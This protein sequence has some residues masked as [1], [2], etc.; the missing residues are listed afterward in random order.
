M[1]REHP[2][3]NFTDHI[4]F[5][6]LFNFSWHRCECC[7]LDFRF[8]SGWRYITGPYY[9]GKGVVKYICRECK[10]TRN[11]VINFIKENNLCLT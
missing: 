10:P 8:E 7:G 4:I 2:E 3:C 11:D 6:I 9:G 1:K 5:P